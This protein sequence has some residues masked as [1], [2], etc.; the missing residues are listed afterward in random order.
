MLINVS[1]TWREITSAFINVSGIWQSISNAF[2]NVSGLWKSIFTAQVLEPQFKVAISQSTNGT[3]YLTTLTG[4]NY[5][6]S[7]GPP[8]LT[9]RFQW[10]NGVSWSDISTGN[11]IN[12][13]YGSLTSY[14]QLLQSTG[15]SVY[16]QPNQVNRFRF[17]VDGTYGAQ[18]ASSISSIKS[19]SL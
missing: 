11:A 7:P 12:P 14:T 18:S 19:F 4:T 2:I 1:G 15:P 5:Y 17:K 9:Y 13:S 6:W 3:T 8:S 16:V 10:W